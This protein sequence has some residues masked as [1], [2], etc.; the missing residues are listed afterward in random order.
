MVQPMRMG[1]HGCVGGGANI[2]PRA[3]VQLYDAVLAGDEATISRL[4]PL[5]QRMGGLF[6]AAGPE[7][8]PI[9][10][11]KHEAGRRGLC[12]A[13][14][15]PPLRPIDEPRLAAMAQILA[16]LNVLDDGAVA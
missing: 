4:D 8:G 1:G 7:N 13:R 5:M 14:V 15:A 10:A 6:A 12:S 9:L 16:D 3:V 11:L 2:W